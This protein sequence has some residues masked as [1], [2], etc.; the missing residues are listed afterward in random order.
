MDMELRLKFVDRLKRLSGRA[1]LSTVIAFGSAPTIKSYKPSSLMSF[2]CSGRN[3]L[4]LWN[5]YGHEI[6][7]ELGMN[8]FVV[9]SNQDSLSVLL[10][11]SSVLESHLAMDK[12]AAFLKD[13]GY[14][15]GSTLYSMLGMLKERFLG[16]CPHEIGIFLGIPVEDVCGFIENKGK[17]CEMCRYWKVYENKKRA[18]YLFRLYDEAKISIAR[19]VVNSIDLYN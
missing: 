14:E 6:C 12:N 11:K 9:R 2:S 17:N 4:G 13:N 3:M 7:K 15:C 19:D 10:F 8:S 16:G 5:Q 18:E 1:Y